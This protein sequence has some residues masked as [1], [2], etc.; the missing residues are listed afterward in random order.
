MNHFTPAPAET[1]AKPA[2][3]QAQFLYDW[4]VEHEIDQTLAVIGDTTAS[5]SG[6]KEEMLAHLENM[7]GKPYFVVTCCL[8]INELPQRHLV[9]K[10]DDST[11]SGKGWTGSVGQALFQVNSMTGLQSFE[12]IPQ[13][14][15]L[16]SLPEDRYSQGH[17]LSTDSAVCYRLVRAAECDV[18]EPELTSSLSNFRWLTTYQ[19]FLLLYMS[20]S[21]HLDGK[22][23]RTLHQIAE[24]V[25]Q[26]YVHLS[27][28]IQVQRH[29]V[30]GSHQLLTLPR[31]HRQQDP[32]A[33]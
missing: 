23:K 32:D 4:L 19:P 31:L 33:R 21:P 3:Q 18:L 14:E 12:P 7:L 13:L 29:M 16:V 5:K 17:E 28:K 20:T 24:W 26:A 1:G 15:P 2:K 11:S 8:H 27:F 25:A 9:A 30:H 22:Q 6:H 10:L